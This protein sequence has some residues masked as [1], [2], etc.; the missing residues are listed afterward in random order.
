MK[1]KV[2]VIGAGGAGLVAAINAHDSGADVTIITK[3]YPTRSQTSMAQVG[4]MQS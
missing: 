3:D 4:S 2:L 1:N